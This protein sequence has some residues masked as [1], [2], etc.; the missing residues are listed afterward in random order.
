MG[1]IAE[2]ARGITGR[3]G[4]VTLALWLLLGCTS[5]STVNVT[6]DLG[7]EDTAMDGG[8]RGPERCAANQD[9]DDGLF[10]NG[11]EQC[12]PSEP[13]ADS[14]GC[15]GGRSPCASMQACNEAMD[16]CV[17]NCDRTPDADRDGHDARECGGD[18]CDDGDP[19]RFPGAGRE[20]C[21]PAQREH[22]E[23]CDPTTFSNAMTRDG[24]RDMDG[25]VDARCCNEDRNGMRSCGRDCDDMD[26]DVRPDQ[27][28]ACNGRDDNCN[29]MID[30][31]LT[32]R[33]YCRDA[34]G[35]GVGRRAS[36][37]MMACTPPA[38]YVLGCDDCDD[39]N[40]GRNPGAPEVCDSVDNDCDGVIDEDMS[41]TF[42]RDSDGDGHGDPR[43]APVTGCVA[44]SGY[45]ASN[46]DC[47]DGNRNR[48]PGASEVCDGVD[49]N[50]NGQTDEGF[51]LN[52]CY[53]DADRDNY[54]SDVVAV[55]TCMSCPSGTLTNSA[56]LDCCDRDARVHPNQTAFFQASSSCGGF[57]YNCDGALDRTPSCDRFATVACERSPAQCNGCQWIGGHLPACGESMVLLTCG[58]TVTQRCGVQG[59]GTS[60]VVGC[61]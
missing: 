56:A 45:V 10:C 17:S 38:G 14:H 32:N 26:R 2:R 27:S 53:A 7:R 4:E 41:R 1:S 28:E 34:D 9:C 51:P 49:N 20:V 50:C 15:L 5:A 43:S 47:D 16:R 23:D 11:A 44:P 13:S 46:D 52:T 31:G 6:S 55:R 35:D 59:R 33:E 36:G 39:G 48:N 61:R 25:Y 54:R 21:D 60:E 19:N 57:D 58:L 37:S 29:G 30:D 40:R 18:D 12:D 22:D 42:Y 24:D 8:A 3:R